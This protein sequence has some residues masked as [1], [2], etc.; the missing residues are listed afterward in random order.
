MVVF[1]SAATTRD[2]PEPDYYLEHFGCPV[3][4]Q[5]GIKDELRGVVHIT[6]AWIALADP[7]LCVE[8]PA[9]YAVH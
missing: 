1:S 7:Y 9:Q 6:P 3:N 8:T 4:G 2:G 5:V